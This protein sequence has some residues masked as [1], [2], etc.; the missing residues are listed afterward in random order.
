M[1]TCQG[2][3]LGASQSAACEVDYRYRKLMKFIHLDPFVFKSHQSDTQCNNLLGTLQVCLT[4]LQQIKHG[5]NNYFDKKRLYFPRFFFVSNSEMLNILSQT[6]DPR[7]VQPY[8]N[9]CFEAI[10]KV[11]YDKNM[12]IIC[13]FSKENEKI[14]FVNKICTEDEQ[15]CV[16]KW[17]VKNWIEVEFKIKVKFR[18]EFKIKVKFKIKVEVNF[19]VKVVQGQVKVEFKINVTFKVKDKVIQGQEM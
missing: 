14:D 11:G 13:M 7:K 16:E 1:A 8:L 4:L 9:R 6:E 12:N 15:G 5:I 17:L 3:D 18:V 10:A 19:K 2:L